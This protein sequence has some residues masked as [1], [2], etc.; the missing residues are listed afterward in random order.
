MPLNL[1]KEFINMEKTWRSHPAEVILPLRIVNG[2]NYPS[3]VYIS[4]SKVVGQNRA[5]KKLTRIPYSR[6]IRLPLFYA[7]KHR[8]WRLLEFNEEDLDALEIFKAMTVAQVQAF[9]GQQL[10]VR[11]EAGI[12][13]G[14]DNSRLP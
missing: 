13:Y 7:K 1:S 4:G 2:E 8:L 11:K 3:S 6:F 10:K 14:I 12:K 5:V 9:Q